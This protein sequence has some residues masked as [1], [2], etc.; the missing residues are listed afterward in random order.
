MKYTLSN[1]SSNKIKINRIFK[2]QISRVMLFAAS[3][4]SA[5]R[6]NRKL[7]RLLGDFDGA[8]YSSVTRREKD[9]ILRKMK[10][11]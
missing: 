11:Q 10:R 4:S 5:L 8:S 6:K 2:T 7:A 3:L 1:Y 9:R